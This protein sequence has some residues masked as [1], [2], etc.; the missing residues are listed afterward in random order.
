M[1]IEIRE[2]KNYSQFKRLEGN[3]DV[4]HVD[5]IVKSIQTVGYILN[6]IIVNEKM[7]V[8]DGQNRL[9]ALQRLGLP[10]HYYIVKGA[11]RETAIALNLGRSN[12]KPMD[13][14]KSYAEG[15]NTSYIY[16]L[17]LLSEHKGYTLQAM[18]GISKGY[19]MTSGW[20]SQK[21]QDG[22]FV[23][24]EAEYEK[25]EETIKDLDEMA[26]AMKSIIG[27]TRAITTSLA[28][29]MNQKQC[30]K[31]RLINAINKNYPIIPPVVEGHVELFLREVSK[32]Y[33]KDLKTQNKKILFDAIYRGDL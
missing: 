25:A 9:M 19:I 14:V 29:C 5:K 1:N 11:T 12:W 27:S 13:Y 21:L 7:E 2:T 23:L 24:T 30:D 18:F 17:K 22:E 33:N 4:T 28:W 26:I 15:G 3:R 6:P 16:L 20:G 10:V 8:I 32:L 31:K